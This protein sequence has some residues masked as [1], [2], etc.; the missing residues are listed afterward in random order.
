MVP[1]VLMPWTIR[2]ILSM[3]NTNMTAKEAKRIEKIVNEGIKYAKKALAKT[4]EAYT[5]MSLMEA[6][7]GKVKEYKSVDE[8][9]R[10]LKI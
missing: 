10:K 1:F 7:A 5:L 3:I 8:L 2:Q 6:R 4:D 9:F